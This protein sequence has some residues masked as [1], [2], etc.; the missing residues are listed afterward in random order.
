MNLRSTKL[1]EVVDILSGF[2]FKSELFSDSEGMPL[3]RIRDVVRGYSETKYTGD[4]DETFVVENG[5]AL[6]WSDPVNTCESVGSFLSLFFLLP[7]FEG[8]ASSSRGR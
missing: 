6:I 5:D 7:F 8:R 1:G 3:V 4:Y 2:A